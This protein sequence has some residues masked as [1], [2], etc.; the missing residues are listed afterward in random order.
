MTRR[1]IFLAS[2]MAVVTATMAV[3]SLVRPSAFERAF[4]ENLARFPLA[5]SIASRDPDLR[6][7]F[8]RQT[9]VAFNGGGWR[10][11]NGALKLSL[12]TEVEVYADDEHIN[13]ISRADLR[14]LHKLE[15]YPA[16]CKAYLVG[17]PE[18]NEFPQ[19]RQ[20]LAELSVIH[21]A[22]AENGFER[23]LRGASWIRPNDDETFYVQEY[24]SRGPIA[25]LTR[26]ELSAALKYIDGEP[27]HFCSGAIKIVRNLLFMNDR[28]AA[29][30]A[31][32]LLANTGKIDIVHVLSRLC[33]EKGSD[34]D[35]S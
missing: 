26:T 33:R 13:A 27:E 34:L 28:D 18:N 14:V 3:V 19:A 6:S 1:E 22:A 8:L 29:R 25:V 32:V 2:T 31:R 15:D 5:A 30:A 24:L 20:E 23:K 10:A 12:A 21:R 4:D 16:A 11:A 9:E 35:C 17:G 7:V